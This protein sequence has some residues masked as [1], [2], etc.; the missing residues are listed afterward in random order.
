MAIKVV[1]SFSKDGEKIFYRIDF[2]RNAGQRITTGLWTY[3]DPKNQVERDHN[4]ETLTILEMKKSHMIL[5]QQSIASGYIPKHRLVTN[6]FDYY[7]EF[8]TQ[9]RRFGNRHLENSLAAL[10]RFQKKVILPPAEIT[11]NYVIRFR[12]YLLDRYN[13]E[14][15]NGLFL[16]VQTCLKSRN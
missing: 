5:E 11:E 16:P 13:G 7:R 12:Q 3:A 14:T 1:K 10:A 2:G 8:V 4:K 15:P 9:N 6:F